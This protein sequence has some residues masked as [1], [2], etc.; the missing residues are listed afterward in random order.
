MRKL[1]IGVPAD[2]TVEYT[3]KVPTQGSEAPLEP[4]TLQMGNVVLQTGKGPVQA[5]EALVRRGFAAVQVRSH[6]IMP[7]TLPQLTAGPAMY[8]RDLQLLVSDQI[9]SL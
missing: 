8:G 7:G 3:R 2:V 9:L 6:R 4:V 1:A 5:A